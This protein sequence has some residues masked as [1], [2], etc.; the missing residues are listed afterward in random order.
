MKLK[1]DKYGRVVL[2]KKLRLH[3]NAETGSEIEVAIDEQTGQVTLTP[4]VQGKTWI[5]VTDWGFPIIHYD[6]PV[7]KTDIDIVEFIKEGR[8]ERMRKTMGDLGHLPPEQL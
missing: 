2:P 5:E 1:V 6:G 3:L 7:E 4:I 8:E